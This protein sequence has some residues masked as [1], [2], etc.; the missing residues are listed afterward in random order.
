MCK[1]WTPVSKNQKR[2]L[3]CHS[4]SGIVWKTMF[5]NQCLKWYFWNHLRCVFKQQKLV[6]QWQLC[7]Y[8]ERDM[9]HLIR[10]QKLYCLLNLTHTVPTALKKYFLNKKMFI[11]VKGVSLFIYFLNQTHIPNTFLCFLNIETCYLNYDT[12]HIF[13]FY[14]H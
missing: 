3:V 9:A 12:K 5:K 6:F 2:R 1:H 7:N 10:H 4:C 14:K 11:S 13:L 8:L